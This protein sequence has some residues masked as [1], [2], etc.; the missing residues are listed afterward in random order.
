MYNYILCL[1][2]NFLF[3]YVDSTEAQKCHLLKQVVT[4]PLPSLRISVRVSLVLGY[5]RYKRIPRVTVIVAR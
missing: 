5:D 1:R 2:F 4:T 3:F